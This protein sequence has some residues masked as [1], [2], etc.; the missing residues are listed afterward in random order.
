MNDGCVFRCEIDAYPRLSGLEYYFQVELMF[1]ELSTLTQE[2]YKPVTIYYYIKDRLRHYMKCVAK[3][4]SKIN[5]IFSGIKEFVPITFDEMHFCIIKAS[6]H[7]LL[8]GY[9][10]LSLLLDFKFRQGLL[11]DEQNETQPGENFDQFLKRITKICKRFEFY[12]EQS[13]ERPS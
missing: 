3:F 13:S 1:T 2:D 12:R 5:N 8:I 7:S 11:V 4:E 10:I 9:H 6:V